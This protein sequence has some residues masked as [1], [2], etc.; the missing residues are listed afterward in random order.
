MHCL[1]I[2]IVTLLPLA[3]ASPVKPNNYNVCPVVFDG[4]VSDNATGAS[5]DQG[6]LPYD[7][8]YDLGANLTWADVLRFP[9]TAQSLF[10][11]DCDKT[12]Q[13]T[14]DDRSIFTPSPTNEQ[15]G[16]RRAELLPQLSDANGSV[17]GIKTLHWSMM[18]D[19]RRKLN[20]THEYQ[21]VWLESSDYSSNQFSLN[22]GALY[23]STNTTAK[24]AKM[25]YLRGSS[26]MDPQQTLWET[27]F[28]DGVWHNFGL[29][30]NFNKNEL[31]VLYSTASKPLALQTKAIVNDLSGLGQFHF[32]MLKKP[33]GQATDITREGFQ[34]AGIHEGI[35]YGGIFEE[36]STAGC[37]SVAPGK[38]SKEPAFD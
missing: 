5:F 3:F 30:L 22:T 9:R 33:T 27:P 12:V 28:T 8:E 13:V 1:L 16:F 15:L 10:D 24:E 32:G 11:P 7:S 25:L 6:L 34:P 35:T 21:L 37:I 36:D 20:Y 14:I 38:R 23:G 26:A 18:S 31:A 17:T 2:P 29:A 19:T 4:R